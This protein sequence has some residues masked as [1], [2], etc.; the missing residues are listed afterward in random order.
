MAVTMLSALPAG[1]NHKPGHETGKDKGGSS[2]GG[3]DTSGDKG[4]NQ[5]PDPDPTP[6]DTD[7][8]TKGKTDCDPYG[9]HSGDPYSHDNC[10]G[11][12]GGHGNGGNGKCAGCGG[13]ADD[14]SPGGQHPGDHN[15]GYECDHNGGVGKGNPAHSKCKPPTKSSS[16]SPSPSPSR[17]PHHRPRPTPSPSISNVPPP[18]GPVVNPGGI[19]I[20][21]KDDNMANGIQ[22]CDNVLGVRFGA[23][24][25]RPPAQ[26]PGV[27]PATLP[28]TGLPIGVFLV[29]GSA[30][31]MLG[32]SL[33]LLYE[34]KRSRAS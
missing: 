30:L 33:V 17:R 13:K 25:G 4:N 1:A 23:T 14:K 3:G 15:N 11:K 24:P 34:R 31:M 29:L 7:P 20:C 21:D 22:P 32:V 27:A 26:Q 28:F 6:T 12:Q 18:P 2:D 8:A 5:D 19:N 9:N 16:P 10:D